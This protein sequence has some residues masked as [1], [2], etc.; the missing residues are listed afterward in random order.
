MKKGGE[1]GI[2]GRKRENENEERRTK[3]EKREVIDHMIVT[4]GWMVDEVLDSLGEWEWD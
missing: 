1:G 3:N 2:G 4:N